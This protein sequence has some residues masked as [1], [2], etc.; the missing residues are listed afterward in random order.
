MDVSKILKTLTEEEKGELLVELQRSSSVRTATVIIGNELYVTR[1]GFLGNRAFTIS[2]LEGVRNYSI[3]H[4]R[5]DFFGGEYSEKELN[6]PYILSKAG[7]KLQSR[8]E[9]RWFYAKDE[10]EDVY[11]MREIYV[12]GKEVP[13]NMTDG[14]IPELSRFIE[15]AEDYRTYVDEQERNSTPSLSLVPEGGSEDE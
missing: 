3:F 14:E 15:M 1:Y 5:K 12:F 10:G 11:V 6:M 9:N 7:W 4:P 2:S 13:R 8:S